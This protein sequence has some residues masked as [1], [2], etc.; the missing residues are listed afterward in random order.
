M[1]KQVKVNPQ[2][3]PQAFS[4]GTNDSNARIIFQ[5]RQK[6]ESYIFPDFLAPNFMN[7][8]KQDRFYGLVNTKGNATIPLRQ[9]LAPLY[10]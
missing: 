3:Q 1:A 2:D 8:W 10:A 7:S 5:E 9:A 6:Y 4:Y